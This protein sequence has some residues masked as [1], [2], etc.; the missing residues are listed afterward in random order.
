MEYGLPAPDPCAACRLKDLGESGVAV[1][2]VGG[3]GLPLEVRLRWLDHLRL[4]RSEA[5][6]TDLPRRYRE[7]FGHECR[8]YYPQKGIGG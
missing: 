1:G 4:A 6:G 5:C 2:K 8:C 3:R 7:T